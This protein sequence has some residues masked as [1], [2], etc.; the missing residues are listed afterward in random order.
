MSTGR[1]RDNRSSLGT[2][3]EHIENILKYQKKALEE[4]KSS[5]SESDKKF[6]E[7]LEKFIK[8]EWG[9]GKWEIGFI[10]CFFG[11]VK[12]YIISIKFF[13]C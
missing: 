13:N 7:S 4:I 6:S 3:D 8:K 10:Q 2:G 11:N 5:L 9:E 1:N 12:F